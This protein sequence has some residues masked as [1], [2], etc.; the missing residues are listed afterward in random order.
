MEYQQRATMVKLVYMCVCARLLTSIMCHFT[1]IL[2]TVERFR[3]KARQGASCVSVDNASHAVNDADLKL[4]LFMQPVVYLRLKRFRK[5][6]IKER[7]Q[8]RGMS[9]HAVFT[10]ATSAWPSWHESAWNAGFF[11]SDY[12]TNRG[13]QLSFGWFS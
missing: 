11:G 13:G 4:P 5:E 3:K 2:S 12:L 7:G 10:Q 6:T 1:G 9:R 8:L